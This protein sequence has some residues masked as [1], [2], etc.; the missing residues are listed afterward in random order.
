[1]SLLVAEAKLWLQL[2][3]AYLG[4]VDLGIREQ[5]NVSLLQH[6]SAL[7]GSVLA[8][9]SI[10]LLDGH[11]CIRADQPHLH[12][13]ISLRI[14]VFAPRVGDVLTGV[15]RRQGTDHTALLVHG[16][17]SSAVASTRQ[18]AEGERLRFVVNSVQVN[19][20][21]LSLV[22]KASAAAHSAP[23]DLPAGP[24]GA[25][26]PLQVTASRPV[27]AREAVKFLQ[28]FLGDKTAAQS[29]HADVLA[30]M[31]AVLSAL[32][33]QE[34]EG[35]EAPGDEPPKKKKKK[36]KDKDA[37]AAATATPP[38]AAAPTTPAAPAAAPPAASPAPSA[39]TASGKKAKKDK[40]QQKNGVEGKEAKDTPQQNGVEGKEGKE[41]KKKK[42]RKS[43]E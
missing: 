43:E 19:E 18:R 13:P 24:S 42:R 9:D 27:D 2:S 33:Q 28:R 7:Q 31:Q 14:L 16:M 39:G 11:G 1:M 20:G 38:T 36:K 12:L 41:G 8:Y 26:S 25:S 34:Q 35:G 4:D 15:V 29:V 32:E 10:G 40:K 22:G 21:M 6:V 3:P 23:A 17:F 30:H 5:L 37:A